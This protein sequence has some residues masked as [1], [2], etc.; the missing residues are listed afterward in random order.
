M[1]DVKKG[2]ESK[3]AKPALHWSRASEDEK[4]AE[5]HRKAGDFGAEYGAHSAA[6]KAARNAGD[7][8]E[9]K[10]HT[11]AMND[12]HKRSQA[13][14]ELYKKQ[15]AELHRLGLASAPFE[16]QKA[17]LLKAGLS[18]SQQKKDEDS[19]GGSYSHWKGGGK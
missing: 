9:A 16:K 3:T 2:A 10:R 8:D 1:S 4:K 7:K 14:G 6:A 11:D 19:D 18:S 13:Q 5:A 15:N 12:A 17:A